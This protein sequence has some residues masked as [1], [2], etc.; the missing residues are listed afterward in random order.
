MFTPL[1]SYLLPAPLICWT[2][3][4]WLVLPAH[5]RDLTRDDPHRRI[6]ETVV[7][8]MPEART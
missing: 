1:P 4:G 2:P 5:W 3:A 7:A 8:Q 6:A